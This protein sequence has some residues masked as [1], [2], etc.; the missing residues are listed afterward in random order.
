[1]GNMP[2]EEKIAR[3]YH[4]D[5]SWRKVLVRLSPDAHNNIVV[6]RMF[7]N[8]HGWPVIKH[9][10]DT[11]FADT[12]AALTADS[13][14]QNVERAR[15]MSENANAAG[16]EVEGQRSRISGDRLGDDERTALDEKV[17]TLGDLKTPEETLGTLASHGSY[18]R[19][20]GQPSIERQDSVSSTAWTDRFFEGT[21]EETTEDERDD[22]SPLDVAVTS[23]H[24]SAAGQLGSRRSLELRRED[25]DRNDRLSERDAVLK[26]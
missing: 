19:L 18:G 20:K 23:R 9:L 10:V 8:A 7:A 21:D 16:D 17:D 14:E 25:N 13:K 12:V 11:H 2:V 24:G 1:M 6:R 4:R 26:K 15:P 5:L 22:I 3:A